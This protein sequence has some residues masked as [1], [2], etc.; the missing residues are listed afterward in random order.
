VKQRRLRVQLSEKQQVILA[1]LL[2]VLIATSF[3]YCLGLAS[4]VLRH[5]WENAPVPWNGSDILEEI[6]DLTPPTLP[7]E[8]SEATVAPS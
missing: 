5:N 8:P 3:L 1:V 2:V 7:T 6:N 4:I